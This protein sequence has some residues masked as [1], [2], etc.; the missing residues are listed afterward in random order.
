[1]VQY[2]QLRAAIRGNDIETVNKI[3]GV[4]WGIF[5]CTGKNKYTHLC[6]YVQHVLHNVHPG[7]KA[8]LS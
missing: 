7:I 2:A 1:M 3:W 6:L 8:N 4:S 5:E